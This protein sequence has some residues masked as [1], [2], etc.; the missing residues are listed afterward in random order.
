MTSWITC[1]QAFFFSRL[2]GGKKKTEEKEQSERARNMDW[3]FFPITTQD[4]AGL[5]LASALCIPQENTNYRWHKLILLQRM[6][7]ISNFSHYINSSVTFAFRSEL[8]LASANANRVHFQIWIVCRMWVVNRSFRVVNRS[9]RNN[10]AKIVSSFSALTTICELL[11]TR[12][13]RGVIFDRN[14]G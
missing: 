5:R 8:I 6:E 14:A 10:G 2:Q 9:F 3:A 1:D 7:L 4:F 12:G 13:A 11:W